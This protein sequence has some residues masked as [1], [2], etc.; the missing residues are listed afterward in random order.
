[1]NRIIIAFS[2]LTFSIGASAQDGPN[3]TTTTTTTGSDL[4][5]VEIGFRYMP[6]I[7]KF[8][9][10][11]SDGNTVQGKGTLGFG[12]GTMIAV[13]INEHWSIQSE[14]IYTSLNQKYTD[15]GLEHDIKVR[16]INV[17]LLVTL[18]TNKTK[19]VNL[20]IAVG[21]QIGWNVGSSIKTSGSGGQDTVQ[22][23]IALKSGDFGIAYGAT[24][25][26]QLNQSRT[27]RLD[28]GYR[29][30][31]GFKDV[32]QQNQD[33]GTYNAFGHNTISSNAGIIGIAFEF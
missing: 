25:G 1:M 8:D 11:T 13:N 33:D 29:G 10:V 32:S 20:G 19:P 17:P 27:I 4:K 18:N 23:V 22:A 9:M 16:Y 31:F 3:T 5:H 12:F 21:P 7:S 6:T 24:V 2:I 28:L 30:V 26:F 15:N 14:I